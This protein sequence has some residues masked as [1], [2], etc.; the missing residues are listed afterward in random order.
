MNIFRNELDYWTED[1]QNAKFPRPYFGNGVGST[2]NGLPYGGRNNYYPQTKF[3]Q[4]LAY[5]R[6]KNVTVGYTLPAKISQ[7]AF[8]QKVRVY[9]SIENAITWDHIHGVMDPELTGGWN[10]ASGIDSH[11][12]GRAMP[13]NRQWSF[14]VQVTF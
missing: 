2:L 9:C 8:I 1:N 5:L 14:G 12:A 7:K 4:N 6:L 10:T 13:F 11:Y 3:L